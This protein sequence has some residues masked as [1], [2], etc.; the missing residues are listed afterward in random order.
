[1]GWIL[2]SPLVQEILA[3]KDRE[4][5]LA[6]LE[7]RFGSVPNHL[8]SRL[9]TV[10]NPKETEK[11][12]VPAAICTDLEKFGALLYEIDLPLIVAAPP[13]E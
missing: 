12:I 3:D 6:L 5:I 13:S 9:R 2:D 7:A 4:I 10:T 11:L 8:A 1:M